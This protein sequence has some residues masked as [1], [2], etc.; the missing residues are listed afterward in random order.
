MIATDTLSPGALAALLHFYADAGVDVLLEDEAVDRFA[1]FAA[2][3]QARARPQ[4]PAP[5]TPAPQM[6]APAAQ[7]GRG[8]Q[9]Q[10]APR[11]VAAQPL[12]VPDAEAVSAAR[13]AAQASRSLDELRQALEGFEH[14]GLKRGARSTIL[15]SGNVDSGVLVVG[16]IPGSDEDAGGSPF[17]GRSG[18]L[19]ERM[20]ASIGLTREGIACVT[21]LPWRPPGNRQPTQAE[22]DVCRPFL[23]RQIEL[24]NPQAVLILGNFAARYLIDGTTSIQTVRGQ[25]HGL[26]VEDRTVPAIASLHPDDLLRAPQSKRLAWQ[27]LLAFR[28][29]L[30]EL[31]LTPQGA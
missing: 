3:R 19:Y 28:M 2:E 8:P 30:D 21:A 17:A 9:A 13:T 26:Q 6:A 7:G 11:A 5:Q 12:P 4:A 27:D 18:A 31:A 15:V 25:W 16:A 20:L 1:D 10:P 23:E 22:M 29:K 14:C 24:C